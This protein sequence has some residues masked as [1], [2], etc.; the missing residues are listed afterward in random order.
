MGARVLIVGAGE[1][2]TAIGNT[3]KKKGAEVAY[4]DADPARV[5]GESPLE[6]SVRAAGFIFLC[7]PSWAVREVLQKVMP[8]LKPETVIVSCSKGLE[9]E[10]GYTTNEILSRLLPWEQPYAL[11]SGPMIAEELVAGGE[12]I[13]ICAASREET[14]ESVAT[15]F[16]DSSVHL[17]YTPFV[18]A[19]ALMGAM[20]NIY[21][22]ALGISDGLG[23]NGNLKGWL[24]GQAVGE[25]SHIA[26][27]VG[28]T[29][30]LCFETAGL[31]DLVATGWSPH[32]R[33]RLLGEETVKK[34]A[35]SR[36][37]EGIASLESLYRRLGKEVEK[38]PLLK[39]LHS[40]IMEGKGPK[41]VFEKLLP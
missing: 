35:P 2:G 8:L 40:V 14:C 27:V 37:G 23:W 13:A 18:H 16:K 24:L 32:S 19:T 1:I 10:T 29:G 28:E 26:G 7:T 36:K 17:E 11:I 6:E 39:A 34:G 20:K 38:L 12:G 3:L 30:K 4:A 31:A 22:V 25:M 9:G 21:A 15:L 5:R 41:E 33:N